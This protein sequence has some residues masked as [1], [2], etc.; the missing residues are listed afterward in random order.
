MRDFLKQT[1]PINTHITN[2]NMLRKWVEGGGVYTPRNSTVTPSSPDL[3]GKIK[4]AVIL[5][6]LVVGFL[7]AR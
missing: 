1:H 4:Y 5:G 6:A 7:L 3:R 2:T